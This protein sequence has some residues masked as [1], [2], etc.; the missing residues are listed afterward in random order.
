MNI[1]VYPPRTESGIKE[2]R[3]KVALVHA[4]AV[5]K[6]ID[7]LHCSKEQKIRLVKELQD[8]IKLK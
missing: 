3:N 8:T 1:I 5:A 7:G 4:E 6:H 2:L